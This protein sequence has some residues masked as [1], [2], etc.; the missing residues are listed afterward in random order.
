MAKKVLVASMLLLAAV[1]VV[2][3]QSRKMQRI[4]RGIQ[5]RVF[6]PKGQWMTGGSVSYSEHEEDNLNF[7]VLKI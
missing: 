2:Q 6:V 1:S 7:L 3:A 4:D 5:E